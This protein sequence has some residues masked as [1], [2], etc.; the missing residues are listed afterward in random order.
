[1]GM[2]ACAHLDINVRRVSALAEALDL[3]DPQQIPGEDWGCEL[4]AK[5]VKA[6]VDYDI[7]DAIWKLNAQWVPSFVLAQEIMKAHASEYIYHAMH[8]APIG[9][10]IRRKYTPYLTAAPGQHPPHI[11]PSYTGASLTF[12]F[13][14]L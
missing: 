10:L 3:P 12:G 6:W 11:P 7:D 14:I 2:Y 5:E 1:M 9:K 8:E 4:T 13:T